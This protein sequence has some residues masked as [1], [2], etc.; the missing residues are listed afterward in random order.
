MKTTVDEMDG[1]VRNRHS[2]I[3]TFISYLIRRNYRVNRGFRKGQ[4]ISAKREKS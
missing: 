1:M 3:L 2:L 4:K